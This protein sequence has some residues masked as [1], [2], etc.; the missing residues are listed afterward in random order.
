MDKGRFLI[1]T[2]LRTDRPIAELAAAHGVSR[3]WLYKLLARY[4]REGFAGLEPRRGG[5]RTRPPGSPTSTRTRSYG[6][7]RSWL[8]VASTPEPRRSTSTCRRRV[9]RCLRCRRSIGCSSPGALSLPSRTRGPRAHGPASQPSSPTS[10]GRPTS[11]TSK[12]P[13]A[14]STRSSTSST[15]TPGSV[16]LHALSSPPARP[17]WC[18]PC[19]RRLWTG[20]IRRG[21]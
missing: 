21:S 18:G 19:T 8:S 9:A 1:E 10:A 11:P 14:S 5:P 13:M 4:R 20:A 7:G 15:T 2:H 17:T 12:W 6:R 3:G 16:S